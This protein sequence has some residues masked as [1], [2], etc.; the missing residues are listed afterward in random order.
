M[1]T[2]RLMHCYFTYLD[3]QLKRKFL[4][5]EIIN[6]QTYCENLFIL[7]SRRLVFSIICFETLDVFIEGSLSP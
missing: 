2:I 7:D 6:I 5:I 3:K 1:L 4:G